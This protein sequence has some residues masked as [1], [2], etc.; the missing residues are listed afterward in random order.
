MDAQ[1]AEA[2]QF[3]LQLLHAL[4]HL[5]RLLAVD[6][7][8]ELLFAA[9]LDVLELFK[10]DVQHLIALAHDKHLFLRLIVTVGKIGVDNAGNILNEARLADEA[11]R[12]DPQRIENEILAV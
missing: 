1:E 12:I 9:A 8:S 4:V 2:G 11:T 10:G 7:D 3:L 6:C 5:N